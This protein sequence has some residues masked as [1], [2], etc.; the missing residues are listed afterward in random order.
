M[1]KIKGGFKMERIEIKGINVEV[2]EELNLALKRGQDIFK[3]AR[4]Q[5]NKTRN[6]SKTEF[7]NKM[8]DSLIEGVKRDIYL[9]STIRELDVQELKKIDVLLRRDEK[10]QTPLALQA[11]DL[12]DKAVFLYSAMVSKVYSVTVSC[13]EEVYSSEELEGLKQGYREFTSQFFKAKGDKD[14]K[15]DAAR[16]AMALLRGSASIKESQNNQLHTT[17]K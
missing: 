14:K 10:V 15:F 11:S 7:V 4:G 12:S 3:N 9:Q 5:G 2:L 17:T 16:K 8:I 1:A 13:C 6:V